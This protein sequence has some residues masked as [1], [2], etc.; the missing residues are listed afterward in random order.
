MG[1][2]IGAKTIDLEWV[3]VHPAG[4]VKPDDPDVKIKFFAAEA[5]RGVG[6]PVYDALG[7]RFANELR[8]DYVTEEMWR[9]KL[10][11]C[12]TL[13]TRL[14]LTKCAWHCKHYTGR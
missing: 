1:E 13:S 8:R 9:N 7:N 6:G 3:Q 12:L 4:F 5:L 11:I 2:A 10:P 14:F